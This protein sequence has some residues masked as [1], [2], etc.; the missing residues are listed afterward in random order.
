MSWFSIENSVCHYCIKDNEDIITCKN[1]SPG[2]NA[3]CEDHQEF[4]E[5]LDVHRQIRKF[6][7]KEQA[8]E[9]MR[10]LLTSKTD[11]ERLMVIN[12]YLN[13]IADNMP[14]YYT[15][16]AVQNIVKMF[17]NKMIFKIAMKVPHSVRYIDTE[18]Y[19]QIFNV[20]EDDD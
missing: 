11:A 6:Y 8:G 10:L 7:C 2:E 5:H 13:F 18:K 15:E 9:L 12:E 3:V 16:K 14:Y 20:Y 19:R 17:L 1:K 4:K